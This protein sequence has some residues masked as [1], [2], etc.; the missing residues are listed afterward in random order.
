MD[1]SNPFLRALAVRTMG[2][3]RIKDITEYLCD[4]LKKALKDEDPYV[5]KTGALC[6]PKM[7]E[8]SP[9]LIEKEGFLKLLVNLINDGNATVVSNTLVAL[10]ICS[11]LKGEPLLNLTETLVQKLLTAMND[12]NEWGVVYILDTLTAYIPKDPQEAE[13]IMERVSSRLAHT[14]SA[15]AL[16][17]IRL[18][19]RYM[20]YLSSAETIRTYNNKISQPLI[21]M[22]GRENEISYL[23][24]KTINLVL[25][26]RPLLLPKE[27]KIFFVNYH[28]PLYVKLEKL[29]VLS[30]IANNENILMILHELKEYIHEV[31][32]EFVRKTVNTMGKCAIKLEKMADK[33]VQ[34]LWE[35]LKTKISYVVQEAVIVIRDIFRKYPNKYEGLL[36][37]I[38]EN[39]NNLDDPEAKASIVW[40]IGE[41]IEIIDNADELMLNF[42]AN[43]KDEADVVQ[44]QILTSCMKLYL[45]RPEDGQEIMKDLLRYITKECENPD[46]RDRGFIYWRLLS[47]NPELAK[48][49]VLSPRPL[50]SEQS[51]TLETEFL[52]QLIENIGYLSSVYLKKPEDFVKRLKDTANARQEA[53]AKEVEEE[54]KEELLAKNP[55][56]EKTEF[57]K[58]QEVSFA[59]KNAG[60]AANTPS[61]LLD[62]GGEQPAERVPEPPKSAGNLL[63]MEDQPERREP[64]PPTNAGGPSLLDLGDEPAPR[65]Y[66]TSVQPQQE[67]PQSLYSTS[68]VQN[69]QAEGSNINFF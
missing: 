11:E 49:I 55:N 52:E 67:I 25:Q 44:Q 7:Y 33:C 46:L 62:I 61:N 65:S 31:D 34:C 60:L 15:V 57:F 16:S 2:C 8:I 30:K 23:V 21:T 3:I 36:S 28:D 22:I 48:R 68:V 19:I 6:V 40:I 50:I 56:E 14:N 43:F 39:L 17:S 37:D 29:E 59:N 63:D 47:S 32:V 58:E 53:I 69:P 10:S 1:K 4:P 13:S 64:L 26:K 35:T 18:I 24:L 12:C 51:Y 38:C 9:E 5:R 66:Q 27:L 20:D 41:Y 45:L 42:V 54:V